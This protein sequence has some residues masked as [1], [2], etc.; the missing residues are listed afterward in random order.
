MAENFSTISIN[1]KPLTLVL[2]LL[3]QEST[4]RHSC[5]CGDVSKNILA[6]SVHF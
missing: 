5:K 6:A 2:N 4:V 1:V 3:P